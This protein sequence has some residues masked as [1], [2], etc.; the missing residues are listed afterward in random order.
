M[1]DE[2]PYLR[3]AKEQ[4]VIVRAGHATWAELLKAR[5]D[6]KKAKR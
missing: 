4:S 2:L 1:N 5:F 6:A 3:W